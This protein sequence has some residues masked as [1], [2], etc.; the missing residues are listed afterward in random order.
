MAVSQRAIRPGE[1]IKM[2]EQLG[3]QKVRQKGSHVRMRAGDCFTTVP[4]HD[5]DVPKVCFEASRE[6]SSHAWE[7]AGSAHER[8]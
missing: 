4:I 1:V 6:T 5:R 2:I 7:K 8:N 3:G